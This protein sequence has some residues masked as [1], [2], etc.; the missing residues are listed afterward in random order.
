MDFSQRIACWRKRGNAGVRDRAVLDMPNDEYGKCL[1]R[2]V[3]TAPG[4]MP[5]AGAASIVEA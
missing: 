5:T 3:E 4:A 1:P 2:Q